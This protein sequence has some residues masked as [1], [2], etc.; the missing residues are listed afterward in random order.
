MSQ[1]PFGEAA[2]TTEGIHMPMRFPGQ[3]AD[4]ESGFSY[5]YF[6][7]YDPTLGR[8]IENDPI[9]LLGGPNTFSYVDADP[10]A[11]S[12]GLAWWSRHR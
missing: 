12:V 8:Y 2:L 9:D 6:R 7:D 5:N 10:I 3:Y 1:T 11:F 4:I